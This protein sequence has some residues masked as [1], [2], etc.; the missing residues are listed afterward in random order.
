MGSDLL[1]NPWV[2]GPF[3]VIGF[4][5]TCFVVVVAVLAVYDRVAARRTVRREVRAARR[6]LRSRPP[7]WMREGL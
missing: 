1:T 6:E 7:A 2:Y 3:A 5:S 4:A